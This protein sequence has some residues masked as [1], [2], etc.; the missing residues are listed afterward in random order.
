[1]LGRT[2]WSFVEQ[3]PR[4]RVAAAKNVFRLTSTAQTT[5][6]VYRT[7]IWTIPLALGVTGALTLHSLKSDTEA[8][9]DCLESPTNRPPMTTKVLSYDA[10]SLR[11]GYQVYKEVCATCHSLDGIR[12]SQLVNTILLES[13]AKRDAAEHEYPGDPDETGEPTLRPGKLTDPLPKPYP[14]E[15]AARFANNGALPPSL[16][17][18]IGARKQGSYYLWSLLT[19]Y[20]APPAGIKLGSNMNYNP[21]FLGTQIAMPPPLHDQMLE[22]D[23][24]TPATICQMAKDVSHFM[25]W[26]LA[27][28]WNEDKHVELKKAIVILTLSGIAFYYNKQRWSVLKTRQLRRF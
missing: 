11:R 24:G 25:E 22:F 1:M 13:E 15:E 9:G 2:F 17:L 7:P 10:S 28:Q 19:G 16:T 6:Q 4:G 5:K 27:P 21:Y 14:N 3:L 18:M 12:Y 26:A 23:D 20:D 8:S